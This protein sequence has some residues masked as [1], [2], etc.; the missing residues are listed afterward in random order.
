MKCNTA[1][2]Q[3]G[4]VKLPR[5]DFHFVHE[6]SAEKGLASLTIA[7]EYVIHCGIE[8]IK[9]KGTILSAGENGSSGKDILSLVTMEAHCTSTIGEPVFTHFW[10]SLLSSELTAALLINFGSGFRK[11]CEQI[12]GVAGTIKIS[13][14]KMAE[15]MNP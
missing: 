14:N 15:I 9:N 11:A 13:V 8:I 5:D 1:G 7:Q 6:E 2:D 4:E 3:E 12:N 10:S